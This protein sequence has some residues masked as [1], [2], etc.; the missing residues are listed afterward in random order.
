MTTLRPLI[1]V[2]ILGLF[3]PAVGT[4]DDGSQTAPAIDQAAMMAALQKAMTPGEHHAF[5]KAMEGKWNLA[6]KAWMAPGQPPMESK[7]TATKTMIHGGRYLQ[8]QVN[9][10]MMGI[11]F[12]G[13]GLTGFDNTGARFVG[14]WI[15]SMTTSIL[16]FEGQRD[17]DVITL[18]GTSKDPMSGQMMKVRTVT[19]RVDDDHHEFEFYMTAP[20][21]PEMKWMEVQYTRAQ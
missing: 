19:R 12:T 2:A 6:T 13:E 8:E 14:T 5:L 11:P 18:T 4:A 1:L 15:D 21:G 10:E 9:G 17:G 7:G 16:M 3:L 20:G